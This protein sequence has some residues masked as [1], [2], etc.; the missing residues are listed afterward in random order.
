[1][2]VCLEMTPPPML[3]PLF[4]CHRVYASQ[5]L[6]RTVAEV[7]QPEQTVVIVLVEGLPG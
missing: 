6:C 2:M 7:S 3:V 5:L 4:P 1:M